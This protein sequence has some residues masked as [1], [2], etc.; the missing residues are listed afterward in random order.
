MEG[1]RKCALPG[2]FEPA[3]VVRPGLD[4]TFVGHY[5]GITRE[6]HLLLF[7]FLPSKQRSVCT[8]VL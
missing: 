7:T 5:M 4:K 1:S 3:S 6:F 8:N 2:C